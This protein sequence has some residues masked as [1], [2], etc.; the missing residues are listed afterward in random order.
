MKKTVL[1]YSLAFSL[2]LMFAACSGSGNKENHEATE[3]ESTEA[4]T[5]AGENGNPSYDPNGAK[6]S[7]MTCS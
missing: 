7:F 5:T 2:I 4:K 3:H 1:I 6:E